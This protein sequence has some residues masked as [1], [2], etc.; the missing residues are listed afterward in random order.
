MI[1]IMIVGFLFIRVLG[2][3]LPLVASVLGLTILGAGNPQHGLVVL[4]TLLLIAAAWRRDRRRRRAEQAA[5]AQ[6]AF[7]HAQAE[8]NAEAMFR[9]WERQKYQREHAALY[10]NPTRW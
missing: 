1:L 8:A 3:L 5:T 10:Q 6:V 2:W 7:I 9:L 4:I